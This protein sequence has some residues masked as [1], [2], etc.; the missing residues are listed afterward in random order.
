MPS[1]R[2]LLAATPGLA[3][4]ALPGCA[5]GPADATSPAGSAS[6]GAARSTADATAF[7]VT[8]AHAHGTTTVERPPT[9]VATMG[10][11]AAPASS[12]A[13]GIPSHADDIT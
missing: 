11:P 3:L 1:R 13:I 12:S 2:S 5:T 9:R 7:P 6:A 8:V 4:L 10:R